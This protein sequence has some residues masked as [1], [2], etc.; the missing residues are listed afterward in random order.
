[1]NKITG[2]Q[3]AIVFLFVVVAFGSLHLLT[4]S[5]PDNRLAQ[6]WKALGF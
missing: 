2:M 6:A 5:F 4:S 1:M 3:G